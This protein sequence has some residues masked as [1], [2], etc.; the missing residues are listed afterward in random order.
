[1]Y[2]D[3]DREKNLGSKLLSLM[4]ILSLEVVGEMIDVV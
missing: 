1:M 3:W 2:K 4:I